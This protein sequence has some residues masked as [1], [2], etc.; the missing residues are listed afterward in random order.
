[1][2]RTSGFTGLRIAGSERQ[3]KK[4]KTNLP[5]PK[6][7][8]TPI[9]NNP[10]PPPSLTPPANNR[11]PPTSPTTPANP[12]SQRHKHLPNSASN[13]CQLTRFSP[14][15]SLAISISHPTIVSAKSGNNGIVYSALSSALWNQNSLLK[16]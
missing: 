10:K 16:F 13:I 9:T 14:R 11:K 1:M 8:P 2:I 4:S 5:K 6:T 3:N 15:I 12:S 7:T